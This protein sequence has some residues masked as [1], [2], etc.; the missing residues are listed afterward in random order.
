MV[1]F[2]QAAACAAFLGL[3][4]GAAQGADLLGVSDGYKDGPVGTAWVVTV[5]G[6]GA[7]EPLF[8][9]SKETEFTFRPIFDFYRA[10]EKE[11]LSLPNDAF[12]FT[13]Y[14]TGNV[15]FG[16]AGNYIDQ[17]KYSDDRHALYGL[18]DIDYTI[19]FGG[20]A[21]YY[22]LPFL[23]TRVEL[24]QGVS[25]AEGFEANLMADFIYKPAEQW[26]FTLGP[27]LK[28]VDATYNSEFFSTPAG[29]LPGLSAYHAS[30]GLNSWGVSG[31]ARYDINE[32]WSARAFA[33]WNHLEGDAADSPLVRY[34][35]DEEQFQAGI[36]ASY[37]F[38]FTY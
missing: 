23:R 34:R 9:G 32:R 5:G 4:A 20:F 8:P 22:P 33:E 6:Y 38:S 11:W 29:Y 28:L 30:G 31:S 21:E 24:L 25:G 16:L 36:G 13:L 3:A 12:G 1:G 37:K 15:R 18:H 27:R 2:R 26:Q 17:R 7:V 35:G 14:Q 19:Q 10:G